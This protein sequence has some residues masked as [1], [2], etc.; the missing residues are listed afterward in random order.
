[1][2]FLHPRCSQQREGAHSQTV[3]TV[4]EGKETVTRIKC[5]GSPR[6]LGKPREVTGEVTFECSFGRSGIFGGGGWR[7]GRVGGCC[8]EKGVSGRRMR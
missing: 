5:R 8:A 1:M 2:W 6:G 3:Q 7:G 4:E